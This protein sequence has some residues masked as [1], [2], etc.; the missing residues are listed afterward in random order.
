[1]ERREA[2]PLGGA[3]RLDELEHDPY[4]LFARLRA[5]EPVTWFD[6]L[7]AW[8]VTSREHALLVARNPAD[9]TVDHPRMSVRAL[10]SSN[11]LTG[12]L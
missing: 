3:A 5:R 6:A 7:E 4:P 2:Y 1:M 10:L 8:V 11:M 12:S 9:Y